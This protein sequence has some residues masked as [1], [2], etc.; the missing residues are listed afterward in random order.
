MTDYIKTFRHL[1]VNV[2]VTPYCFDNNKKQD[3]FRMTLS[4]DI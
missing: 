2:K 1:W 4:I 3:I